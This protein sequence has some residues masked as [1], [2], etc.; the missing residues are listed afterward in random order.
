M[1]S[2][3]L[4]SIDLQIKKLDVWL[5]HSSTTPVLN[6]PSGLYLLNVHLVAAFIY[7]EA[8]GVPGSDTR[9]LKLL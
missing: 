8:I 1:I 9:A 3:P 6:S 4:I 5:V 7:F 2:H